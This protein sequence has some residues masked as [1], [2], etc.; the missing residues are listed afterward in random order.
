MLAM[1][2]IA[3]L[4][5]F[6]M[7]Q[8][9]ISAN[10]KDLDLFETEYN[11]FKSQYSKKYSLSEDAFRFRVFRENVEKINQHNSDESQ[12]YLMGINQFAD[13]TTEEFIEKHLVNDMMSM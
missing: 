4:S 3:S 9:D 7:P 8:K 13:L 11:N 6:Y 1:T 5:V 12:T 2:L 10:V